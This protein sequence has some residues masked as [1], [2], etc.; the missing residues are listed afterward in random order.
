MKVVFV[1]VFVTLNV[2]MLVT[3]A[4][5]QSVNT[6]STE[7][8]RIESPDKEFSVSVPSDYL[9]NVKK[10]SIPTGVPGI[11]SFIS[12]TSREVFAYEN[13]VTISVDFSEQSWAKANLARIQFDSDRSPLVSEFKIQGVFGKIVIYQGKAYENKLFIATDDAYY[14]VSVSGKSKNDPAVVRFL[15]SIRIKGESLFKGG[16]I[17]VN[18]KVISAKQLK[19]SPEIVEA[20]KIKAAKMDRKVTLTSLAE[21]KRVENE[22]GVRP[23]FVVSI[24]RPEYAGEISKPGSYKVQVK[25]LANG[26]VGDILVATDLG[27]GFAK[28]YAEAAKNVKFLPAEKNGVPVDSFH[29]LSASAVPFRLP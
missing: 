20:L 24:P 16:N 26:Q 21:F 23:A 28:S 10:A 11:G 27:E 13:G 1:L 22:A 8:V 18:E 7:W 9:V 17:P 15:T 6:S 12:N 3:D 29:V 19:S 14:I 4:L 2:L 25:L 5:A